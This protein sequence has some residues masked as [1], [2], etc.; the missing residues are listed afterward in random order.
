MA[1]NVEGLHLG[2]MK[3]AKMTETLSAADRD[4]KYPGKDEFCEDDEKPQGV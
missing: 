1:E 4:E 2:R 3:D